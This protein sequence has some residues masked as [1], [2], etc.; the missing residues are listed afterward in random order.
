MKIAIKFKGNKNM[1]YDFI[2]SIDLRETG[3]VSLIF[4]D[5]DDLLL[6]S[7]EKV[8]FQ[9]KFDSDFA[10]N[11]GWDSFGSSLTFKGVKSGRINGSNQILKEY[12]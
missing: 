8:T 5:G 11:Q 3:E 7:V 9:D 2:R 4:S 10:Q 6:N 12:Y 1:V